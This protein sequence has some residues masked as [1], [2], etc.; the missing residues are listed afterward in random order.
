MFDPC[1]AAPVRDTA[2]PRSAAFGKIC[3]GKRHRRI[4]RS[5]PREPVSAESRYRRWNGFESA[6][7]SAIILGF[8][9]IFFGRYITGIDDLLW[10]G[11]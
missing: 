7:R 3:E 10:P 11:L 1:H 9:S 5:P 8:L 4:K 2:V 6:I